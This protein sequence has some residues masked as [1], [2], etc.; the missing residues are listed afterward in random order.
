LNVGIGLSYNINATYFENKRIKAVTT[1]H[2]ISGGFGRGCTLV[3]LT[4]SNT[5]LDENSVK[6]KE[7]GPALTFAP[8][9]GINL[10]QINIALFYSYD[11][12]LT[13]NV[14]KWNYYDK[15]YFG[16][17]PGMNL[18]VFGALGS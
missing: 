11:I 9:I 14:R 2:S 4:P 7:S 5:S 8:G 17:G 10:K 6:S 16:I 13:N 3:S 1:R 18:S 12:P 15:G